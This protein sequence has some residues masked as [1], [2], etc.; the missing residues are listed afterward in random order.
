MESLS[1]P[2]EY[3]A[4]SS[5]N[6][7]IFPLHR[8]CSTAIKDNNV[9]EITDL[10]NKGADPFLRDNEGKLPIDLVRDKRASHAT[11]LMLKFFMKY[12]Y[13]TCD[14]LK[15]SDNEYRYV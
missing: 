14:E 5:A 1:Y 7:Y 4:Y 3:L 8:L 13:S 10:L 11:V 2:R 9:G 6:I 12:R 15:D